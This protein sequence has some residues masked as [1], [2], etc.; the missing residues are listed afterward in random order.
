MPLERDLWSEGK[1]GFKLIQYLSL[2][3]PA[4]ADPVGVNK[5]IIEQNI[6]GYLCANADE[7]YQAL[8]KLLTDIDLR[9]EF[10]KNGRDSIVKSYSI[11]ANTDTFLGLFK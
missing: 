5:D 3:I 6:N 1:C 10:G 2:G 11:V 4:V 7:W 8:K 9:K